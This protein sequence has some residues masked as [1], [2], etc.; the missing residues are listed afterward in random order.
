MAR[1]CWPRR[2]CTSRPNLAGLALGFLLRV[3]AVSIGFCCPTGFLSFIVQPQ[4]PR[5]WVGRRLPPW[6][7]S[8]PVT[9]QMVPLERNFFTALALARYRLIGVW[10]IT[11]IGRETT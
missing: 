11:P 9:R 7:Q 5:P 3:A 4:L 1:N 6:F 8:K 10:G 2:A